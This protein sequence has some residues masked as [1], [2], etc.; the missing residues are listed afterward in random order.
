MKDQAGPS[1][2]WVSGVKLGIVRLGRA[3]GK[4]KYTLLDER[5][6]TLVHEYSFEARVEVDKDGNGA[7]IFAYAYEMNQG[8]STGQYLHQLLW[9]RHFGGVAPGFRVAHLNG[10]TMDNR[11]ENLALERICLPLAPHV[12]DV[13]MP[14]VPTSSLAESQ[15]NKQRE[16]SLY[17][18]AIQQL[19][20]EHLVEEGRSSVSA[21]SVV[22]TTQDQEKPQSNNRWGL[23]CNFKIRQQSPADDLPA[24][25]PD[26]VNEALV[27]VGASFLE[28]SGHKGTEFY[29]Q[30]KAKQLQVNLKETMRPIFA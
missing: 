19:P 22:V 18:A 28:E 13:H 21:V 30:N 29:A 3:A 23:I 4:I 16:Q 26:A 17:W 1:D 7:Q 27:A 2:S 6:I 14:A 11:L 12:A 9:E 25:I 20:P 15:P 5:D 24:K 8:K 10:V